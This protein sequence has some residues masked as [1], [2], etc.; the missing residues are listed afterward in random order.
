L[1]GNPRPLGAGMLLASLLTLM[2]QPA[3]GQS[4]PVSAEIVPGC[5][6][7]GSSASQGLAMGTIA[8]GTHSAVA[9][10]TVRAAAVV[11]GANAMRLEC[12]PGLTLQVTIDA[13]QHAAGGQRR[14]A[15][16]NTTGGI[17]YGVFIDPQGS[18]PLAANTAVPLAV[19]A[20]GFLDLPIHGI[21][22][23][24]GG[25]VWPGTYSDLLQVTVVW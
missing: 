7:V 10:G 2:A 18:T 8:F 11:G 22:T 20:S 16:A 9:S 4:I 14:L 17:S 13:G 23:L 1:C 15:R 5:A 24:P 12:T 21:A 19:P 25:G 6:V 3:L